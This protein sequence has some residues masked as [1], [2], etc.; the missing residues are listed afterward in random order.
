MSYLNVTSPTS[1]HTHLS[2]P[3]PIIN[4]PLDEILPLNLD[5]E[6]LFEHMDLDIPHIS[7]TPKCTN[8]FLLHLIEKPIELA[9]KPSLSTIITLPTKE[10]THRE[11]PTTTN[12][13]VLST[14]GVKED[15]HFDEL[16]WA[17][18]IEEN[19]QKMLTFD[20]S[21]KQRDMKKCARQQDMH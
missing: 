15:L 20:V 12:T 2:L 5:L 14:S 4:D 18:D 11:P 17:H 21:K 13:Q 10:S 9:C 16:S 7:P 8:E 19:V 3:L 1:P 6:E